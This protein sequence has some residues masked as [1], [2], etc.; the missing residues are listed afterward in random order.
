M[1]FTEKLAPNSPSTH[2][3][4]FRKTKTKKQKPL[5]PLTNIFKKKLPGYQ[6]G[7]HVCSACPALLDSYQESCLCY[8]NQHVCI[9]LIVQLLKQIE[10]QKPW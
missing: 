3:Y 2:T 4:F 10:A 1:S 5:K 6:G 8:W 7:Y 9:Q